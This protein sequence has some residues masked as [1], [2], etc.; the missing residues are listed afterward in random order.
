[1]A[2]FIASF[3]IVLLAE[4]GDK[5]QLLA[6]AFAARYSAQKVL[7]AV[8][9]A[10]LLNHSLAVVAGRFLTIVIPIELIS[11]IAAL[12]FIAF[13]LWTIRGDRLKGEDQRKI[14][15]GPILTVGIAFFLVEMGDKTQL[16]T[17]SLA[18]QYR[19]MFSVLMGTTLAMVI[20]DAIG[21]IAG[22]V[23][24]RHIPEQT[25]KWISAG[26]FV[27]FGFTGVYKIL[28][29]R[30][31]FFYTLMI[32]LVISI[33]TAYAAYFLYRTKKGGVGVDY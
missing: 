5:T 19:N 7:I 15:F 18:V 2:A 4:M 9:L 20:A 28:I 24:K 10:T 31:D 32:M 29:N 8:S 6:M 26:I 17:I 25:I 12:S 16:A 21:I 27:L 13:G 33:C 11:F 23:M 3:I 1:M 14:R 30:L 22:V